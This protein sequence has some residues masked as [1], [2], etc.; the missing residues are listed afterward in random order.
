MNLAFLGCVASAICYLT[1]NTALNILGAL[2]A[3][4]YLY[5]VPVI[6][7]FVATISLGETVTLSMIV[8]GFL[9][10]FGLFISQRA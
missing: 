8:G 5:A 10:L 7:V 9:V 6:G 4:V 1:W 2:K 3:S